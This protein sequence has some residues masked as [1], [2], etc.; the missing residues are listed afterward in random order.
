MGDRCQY[1]GGDMFAAVPPADTYFMK[2]ILHD[3]NDDECVGILQKQHQAAPAGGRVF[4]VEH[5]IPGPGYAALCEAVR[6]SHDVLGHG[7]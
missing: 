7:P 2:M 6:H 5:V 3:W 4:V 1:I